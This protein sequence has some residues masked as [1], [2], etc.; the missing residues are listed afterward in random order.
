LGANAEDRGPDCVYADEA[1][2][3]LRRRGVIVR[4]S[5]DG[6]PGVRRSCQLLWEQFVRDAL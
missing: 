3:L 2:R 1:V 4:R 6:F 5:E